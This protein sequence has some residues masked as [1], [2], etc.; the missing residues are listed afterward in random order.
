M[1]TTKDHQRA[2]IGHAKRKLFIG[3]TIGLLICGLGIGCSDDDSGPATETICDDSGD[4]DGDGLTDCDDPDCINDPACSA[5]TET[6]C[7]DNNDDDNDGLTDCD[8]DDCADDP[9][10]QATQCEDTDL[11][12]VTQ[13]M[14]LNDPSASGDAS[15]WTYQ[16]IV[17][18]GQGPH[19]LSVDLLGDF[20][21]AGITTGAHPLGVGDEA[22]YETCGYC[23]LL[24]DCAEN[25][26][27][28]SDNDRFFF[29]T[30]GTLQLDTLGYV[31]E[32]GSLAG[33]LSAVD[34]VEVTIDENFVST[35][36]DGGDCYHLSADYTFDSTLMHY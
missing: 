13:D 17:D 32:G 4:G 31:D 12:T 14:A 9:S 25:D 29:A 11:G 3:L 28:A 30:A 2:G 15:D 1:Q 21:T 20:A 33:G 35:P 19:V 26:C 22:N 16:A 27:A 10:C 24:I 23:V 8:D 18:W 36:V 5:V 6:N 34:W 7:D